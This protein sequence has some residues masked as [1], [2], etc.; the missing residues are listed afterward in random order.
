MEFEKDTYGYHTVDGAHVWDI[1]TVGESYFNQC[2][3]PKILFDRQNHL[4]GFVNGNNIANGD[5][6]WNE[7]I[8]I[9]NLVMNNSFFQLDIVLCGCKSILTVDLKNSMLKVGCYNDQGYEKDMVAFVH[10]C[11]EGR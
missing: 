2:V 3:L 10:Q 5:Q 1:T 9:A 8:K 7:V 11:F 6:F 4:Y